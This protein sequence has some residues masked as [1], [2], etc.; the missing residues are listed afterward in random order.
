MPH[1]RRIL[2]EA[3]LFVCVIEDLGTSVGMNLLSYVVLKTWHLFLQ[4]NLL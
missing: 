2:L 1:K 3:S 4:Y